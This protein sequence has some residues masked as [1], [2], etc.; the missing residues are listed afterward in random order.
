MSQRKTGH[1]TLLDIAKASGF[2]VSTVS[3]VL[4]NA[5]RSQDVAAATRGHVR[6]IAK[7][8]GYHPDVYARSLR[9]RHTQTVGVLAYDLSDPFCIPV[10][11]GIEGGLGAS[12]YFPLLMDAQA[13][14]NLF[15][16]FLSM[17][18]E[19]RVDGILVIASWIFDESNL[20]ADVNKNHVPIVIVGRDMTHL[21]VSSV[22]VDNQAGGAMAIRHLAQLGHEKIA[23]ICGPRELWDSQPR[24]Q[25]IQRAAR[26]AGIHL[27]A[28]LVFT[29]PDHTT[30]SFGFDSGQRFA[31]ELV[32][33]GQKFTAVVAFDDLTALGVIRGLTEAGYR[34][35]QDCSVVGF[36]DVLPAKVA[37]PAVTTISQPLLEMGQ[38]AAQRVLAE[39]ES[40]SR[41]KL[42]P[43]L[44]KPSLQLLERGSSCK[45]PAQKS[46]K[47]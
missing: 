28:R 33:S 10:I 11:R 43:L 27:D 42:P 34:V 4:S 30:S 12:G 2:S 26:Q 3:L 19:R 39:I 29:L 37:T 16:R 38:I 8:M 40:G 14:R 45:A 13:Q 35:P 15:D 17:T 47:R 6:A 24:W 23:V 32:A 22:L 7:Q 31:Q 44:H 36:D 25:G 41:R 9:K 18:L 1:V 21:G 20:L 5:P 46:R